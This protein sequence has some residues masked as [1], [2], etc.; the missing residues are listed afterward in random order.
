MKTNFKLIERNNVQK[1]SLNVFAIIISLVILSVTVDAQGIWKSFMEMSNANK[2]ELATVNSTENLTTKNEA[3]VFKTSSFMVYSEQESEAS[4]KLEEWMINEAY[5]SVSSILKEEIESPMELE[6]WMTNE[7]YFSQSV[8]HFTV[9]TEN[10]LELEDWMLNERYFQISKN[11]ELPLV[12]ENWMFAE[13]Y[14]NN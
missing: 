3:N 5:F 7:N 1:A 14:W 8:I 13:N 11:E 4:L 9:E 2:N 10:A 6:A 12:L